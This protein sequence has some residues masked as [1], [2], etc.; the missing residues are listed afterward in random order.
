MA[1]PFSNQ[2][3]PMGYNKLASLMGPHTEVAVFR[4]FAHMNMFNLL[5]MQAE[6]QELERK[7][8]VAYLDDQASDIDSVKDFCRDFSKLRA[9][10]GTKY[11]D[12][13]NSIRTIQ[14]KLEKY[15][16]VFKRI[17]AHGSTR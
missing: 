2:D 15:S 3:K 12:Q 13:L 5:F 14:E 1:Q 7:F 8:T 9:S 11:D 6:L 16:T 4:R 17:N 10:E